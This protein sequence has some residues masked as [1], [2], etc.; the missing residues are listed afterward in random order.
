[1]RT[2]RLAGYFSSIETEM[3]VRFRRRVSANEQGRRPLQETRRVWTP[4]L[5][6][7]EGKP[8]WEIVAS[9]SWSIASVRDGPSEPHRPPG[10][11]RYDQ[12]HR[13]G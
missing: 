11:R 2:K 6:S 4:A 9:R 1:M 12:A 3:D 13:P 8:A 10:W 7:L 5:R